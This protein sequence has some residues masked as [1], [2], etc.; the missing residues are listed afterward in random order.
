MFFGLPALAFYIHF[1]YPIRVIDFRLIPQREQCPNVLLRKN[2]GLEYDPVN[3]IRQYF[4]PSGVKWFHLHHQLSSLNYMPNDSSTH[5]WPPGQRPCCLQTYPRRCHIIPELLT[6]R[7]PSVSLSISSKY[8]K[9]SPESRKK[10]RLFS[11]RNTGLLSALYP[12]LH[13][14]EALGILPDGR[15]VQSL[16]IHLSNHRITV[17]PASRQIWGR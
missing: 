15:S 17:K 1:L 5:R 6:L 9:Y 13:S 11:I 10:S 16:D 14:I 2:I 4:T 8:G 7:H 3:C 12:G